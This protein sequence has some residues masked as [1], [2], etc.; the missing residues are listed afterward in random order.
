MTGVVA[1][2]AN[3]RVILLSDAACY[4]SQTGEVVAFE[5]KILPLPGT[6]AV[7]ALR[8][9]V[10]AWPA[11]ELACRKAK[12]RSLDDYIARAGAIFADTLGRL[13]DEAAHAVDIIVTGWS[14]ARRQ[15]LL[16]LQA[17]H[18]GHGVPAGALVS[19][20]SFCSVAD[21]PIDPATFTVERGVELLELQRRKP[22]AEIG[23]GPELV[24]VGGWVDAVEIRA[25]SRPVIKRVHS[26]P[27]DVIGAP[28]AARR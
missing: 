26:W 6:L 7:A 9:P 10:N 24:T 23:G 15:A 5:T 22:A 14:A 18:S 8:G 21:H 27:E 12:L 16:L 28:L 1:A 11:F 4:C 20:T 19:V 17:N 2:A 25:G 13:G 3:G